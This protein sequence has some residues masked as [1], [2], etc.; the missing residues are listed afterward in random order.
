MILAFTNLGY[1]LKANSNLDLT[2]EQITIEL[3]K[4]QWHIN[5][6]VFNNGINYVGKRHYTFNQDLTYSSEFFAYVKNSETGELTLIDKLELTGTWNINDTILKLEYLDED[7]QIETDVFKI[8]SM[9]GDKILANE[10]YTIS[11]KHYSDGTVDVT[12]EDEEP[13]TFE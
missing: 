11:T 13:V 9:D 1:A 4:K 2:D 3:T 5:D 12:Y 7:N 8:L 6:E 10:Y